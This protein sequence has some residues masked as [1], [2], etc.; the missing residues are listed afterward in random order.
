MHSDSPVQPWYKEFW[1]WFILAILAMAVVLGL[2]LAFIAVQTADTLVV[3][4]YYDAGKGI[5]QSLERERLAERLSIRGQLT[6]DNQTGTAELRLSGNSAPQLLTLNLISPTQAEKD[7]RIVLQPGVGQVYRGLL[8]DAI[9]GRRFV[10]V[11]GMEGGQEWRL[12]EEEELVSGQ[13]I[14]L[15]N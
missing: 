5:N 7:R 14:L 1:V 12:F 3:S 8:P 9:G 10:E 6:L 4:N 15:G 2:S 11:L 13:V